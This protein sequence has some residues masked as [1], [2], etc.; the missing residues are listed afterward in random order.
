MSRAVP[1]GAALLAT[2]LFSLS[3]AA[4]PSSSAPATDP[5]LRRLESILASKNDNDPRLDR[6]FNHLSPEARRAFRRKYF[7]LRPEARNERGTIVYLLGKNL[8]APEDWAFM[9]HVASEPPC[10]SLANCAKPAAGAEPGDAVTLAYPSLV[11]LKQA[12]RELERPA[13]DTKDALAVVAAG[14]L[15]KAAPVAR[16]ARQIEASLDRR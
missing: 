3:R 16:L 12:Q 11:A 13:G 5:S 9:K 6:D 2:G 4:P 1:F 10:L 8:R 14:Q 7:Q 15:S